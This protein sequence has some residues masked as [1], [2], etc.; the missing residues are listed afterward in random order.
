MSANTKPRKRYRPRPVTLDTMRLAMRRA[1]KVPVAEID[2][3]M[4]PI[5]ASFK[6]MREGVATEDEWAVLAGTVELGL[7]IEHQGVVKGLHG[8][9]R[10]AEQ[11]LAAIQRRAMAGGTWRPT[12]LYYQEIE[13]LDTFTWLHKTQ[14]E[15][16]SEGEWRKAH[17][18][19]VALVLGAQGRVVDL[20]DLANGGRQL[21]LIGAGA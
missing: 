19:A 16:L 18:R 14:L 12:A 4:A 5:A 21:T 2:E 20:Q 13:A 8:H 6:A 17:D 10:A 9:L 1:A 7:A 3:V 15:N 11:A